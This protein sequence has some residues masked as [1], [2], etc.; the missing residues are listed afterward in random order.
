[1]GN[2]GI[3]LLHSFTHTRKHTHKQKGKKKKAIVSHFFA[4]SHKMMIKTE[5]FWFRN[6]HA[7]AY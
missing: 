4:F 2:G 5:A 3:N 6:N 7:R 1:M